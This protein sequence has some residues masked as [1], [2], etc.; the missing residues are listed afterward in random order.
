MPSKTPPVPL[1]TIRRRDKNKLRIFSR[2]LPFRP[3]A[4]RRPRQ[5]LWRRVACSPGRCKQRPSRIRLAALGVASNAPPGFGLRPRACEQRPSRVRLAALGVA[6]NA[7]PGFGL[8][9]WALRATPLQDSACSPGRC[10]QRPSRVRLR[11]DETKQCYPDPRWPPF[12]HPENYWKN[13][14]ILPPDEKCGTDSLP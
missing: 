14:G 7:P 13:F 11:T 1:E 3:H 6:S 8:R 5:E 12:T 10:E 9:P 4:G 2:A